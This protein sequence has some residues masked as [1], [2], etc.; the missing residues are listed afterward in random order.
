MKFT[1]NRTKVVLASAPEE[2]TTY[3]VVTHESIIN[4]VLE[5]CD[6]KNV[7]I[8][9]ESYLTNKAANQVVGKYTL[10]LGPDDV[11]CQI[12]FK[13]SYDKTMSLG[14]AAGA[15]V[16]I[17]SNGVVR[18][19]VSY[20]KKHVG[21][22]VQELNDNLNNTY[23]LL[24]Q[25]LEA[26]ITDFTRF[27]SIDLSDARIQQLVGRMFLEDEVINTEQI[28]A[29]KHEMYHSQHFPNRTAYDLYNW[30]NHAL[31]SAHPTNYLQKHIALHQLFNN[32][33]E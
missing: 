32:E 5:F 13:N 6:K 11:H 17:C 25:E 33:F 26:I 31:K 28:Q 9:S 8:F 20:K 4:S 19:E 22:I 16:F 1:S 18:G 24:E 21:T 10:S 30:T 29:L 7:K 3:K 27:K 15:E 2:T 12:A 23:D 14:F